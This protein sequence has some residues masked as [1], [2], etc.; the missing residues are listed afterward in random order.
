MHLAQLGVSLADL[1]GNWS[2]LDQ[3]I[4]EVQQILNQHSIDLEEQKQYS[5]RN[6]LFIRKLKNLPVKKS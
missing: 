6:D 5:M 1:E 4:N 2:R 3:K